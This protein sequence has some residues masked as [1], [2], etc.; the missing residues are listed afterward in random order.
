MVHSYVDQL[1]ETRRRSAAL[2][3]NEKAAEV[4]LALNDEVVATAQQLHASTGIAYSLVRDAL[5][6]LVQGGAVTAI[7]RAGGSRSPQYY[8]PVEGPVWSALV[9]GA[10]ALRQEVMREFAGERYDEPI[11][12]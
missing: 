4:M 5:G 10:Q 12:D 7:P 9:A 3:G 8:K 2:F 11:H 1:G 6:R